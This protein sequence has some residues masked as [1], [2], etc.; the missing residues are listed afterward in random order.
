MICLLESLKLVKY[1]FEHQL[2]HRPD[3]TLIIAIYHL[4]QYPEV[5]NTRT[6][7]QNKLKLVYVQAVKTFIILLWIIVNLI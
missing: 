3:P 4:F 2:E 1:F 5:S 7:W 6:K